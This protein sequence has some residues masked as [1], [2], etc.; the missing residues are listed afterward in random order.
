[1]TAE[2]YAQ[3]KMAMTQSMEKNALPVPEASADEPNKKKRRKQRE[4][5]AA[6]DAPPAAEKP[7][8]IDSPN[9]DAKALAEKASKEILAKLN[10]CNKVSNELDMLPYVKKSLTERSFPAQ[11]G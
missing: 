10:F 8:D 1:M 4:P 11:M 9:A 5:V 2:Q 7:A 3:V 6:S